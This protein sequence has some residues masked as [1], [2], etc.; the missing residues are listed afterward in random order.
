MTKTKEK[1]EQPNEYKFVISV[2]RIDKVSYDEIDEYTL[3]LWQ[4]ASD[5]NG[6]Y[7]GWE[8]SI[9]E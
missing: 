9:E 6:D 4:K 5:L 7:D 2:S 3:E 1:I 8:T